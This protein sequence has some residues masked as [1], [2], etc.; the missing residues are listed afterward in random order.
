MHLQRCICAQIPRLN[1]QTK[2]S[3]IIHHKELKRTTNSGRLA[4]AALANSAM[5]VRGESRERLDL[6]SLLLPEYETYVL[7]PAV[8][9]MDIHEIQPKKPVH[10]IVA[11]GN[12][13][14][15]SKVHQRHQELRDLP[16]VK[17]RSASQR[18]Y[19]LRQ[20][21]FPDGLS[22]LEAIAL[23]MGV[24][25]G[26]EARASLLNLYHAKLK[27]TLE[28]RGIYDPVS[29]SRSATISSQRA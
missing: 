25:E 8:D 2:L 19:H 14:Q 12:W 16:R 4:V 26:E 5:I 29:L 11:D 21:H 6:S 3:L 24:L 13:R 9:A 23:T 7:Y 22:T 27:A 10:L 1:L 18:Q 17:V 28:G 15:A 20:E